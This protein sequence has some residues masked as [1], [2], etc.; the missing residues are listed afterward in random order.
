MEEEMLAIT[1]TEANAVH[2]SLEYAIEELSAL[3]SDGSYIDSDEVIELCQE[4]F[5][6]MQAIL[7][8]AARRVE[9]EENSEPPDHT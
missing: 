6:I 5:D 8:S 4:A 7:S 9:V 1:E 3:Q 2:K